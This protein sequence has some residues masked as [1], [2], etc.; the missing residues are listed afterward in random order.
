MG[1]IRHDRADVSLAG[2]GG[3][4]GVHRRCPGVGLLC[5]TGNPASVKRQHLGS[6]AQELLNCASPPQKIFYVLPD[7]TGHI[8]EQHCKM[9]LSKKYENRKSIRQSVSL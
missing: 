5:G 6:I 9:T 4:G 2:L 3:N 7:T 8:W 1:Q